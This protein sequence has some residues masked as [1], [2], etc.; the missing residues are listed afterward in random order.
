MMK[1]VEHIN[2]HPLD[3]KFSDKLTVHDDPGRKPNGGR[4]C[5]GGDSSNH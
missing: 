1:H 5:C 3:T 2:P 4:K